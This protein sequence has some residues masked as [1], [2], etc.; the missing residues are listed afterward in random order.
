M[1]I[2][3]AAIGFGVA[4]AGS[5]ILS[6]FGRRNEQQAQQ[7]ATNRARANAYRDQLAM[8]S[9]TFQKELGVFQQAKADLAE[10]L[11]ESERAL[12]RGKT[13]IDKQL[14]ETYGA[15]AF[16]AEN[17]TIANIQAQGQIAALPRGVR[18]RASVM[19]R[20]AAGRKKGFTADDL[21]RARFGSMDKYRT[22]Q[23]E[24]NAYRKKLYGR[25]PLAPTMAPAPSA[26]VM[27]PGPSALSLI[28]SIGS[29]LLGG[30]QGGFAAD[31]WGT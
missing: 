21:L 30:V 13:A 23:D 14:A 2:P 19:L 12:E 5:G 27:A 15:A 29:S 28:G 18:D 7:A 20:G 10:N 22:M 16:A 8:R 4:T 24:A 1:P 6:A 11:L 26:P 31:K 9:Y 3:L 25:M 17:E